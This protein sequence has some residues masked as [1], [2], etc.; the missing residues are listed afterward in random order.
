MR[1][2]FVRA[3][4]RVHEYPDGSLA[5]FHG[6]RRVADYDAAGHLL[7]HQAAA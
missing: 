2:H 4:V 1:P 3:R 7:N 6:P 5:I